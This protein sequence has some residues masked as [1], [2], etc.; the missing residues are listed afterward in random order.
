MENYI[1]TK[2]LGKGAFGT[3][4]KALNKDGKEIALKVIEGKDDETRKFALEEIK[5]LAAAFKQCQIPSLVCYYGGQEI[6]N[7]I[8]IEM[9][10]V[11]GITLDQFASPL[12]Y[13]NPV[14]LAK[15]LVSICMD[16][17]PGLQF[18]HKN[19]IIHR[20]IKPE[21]IL[22]NKEYQP[23]LIDIGL[24]CFSSK[25]CEVEISDEYLKCCTGFVG[26]PY[27]MSPETLL[28]ERSYFKSDL[29]SLASSIYYAMSKHY[30]FK[31]KLEKVRF[32]QYAAV[33]QK[34]F[35]LKTGNYKLDTILYW[36]LQKNVEDRISDSDL[37]Y[38]LVLNREYDPKDKKTM[39]EALDFFYSINNEKIYRL[40]V[41]AN[42]V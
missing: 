35:Y 10:Y 8:Y 13:R 22:I 21:N 9:E 11:D 26:S 30:I 32:L 25:V 31:P 41:E 36:M 24:G 28:Q 38:F 40:L 6:G 12:R 4:Y 29:W 42:T 3:V 14:K 15:Y 39:D 27:F 23:K 16:L 20:D 33:T 2:I 37:W 18:L 17:V 5:L 7:K 1:N 34:V 19:G